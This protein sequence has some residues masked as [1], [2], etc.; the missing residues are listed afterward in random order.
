[1][2]PSTKRKALIINGVLVVLLIAGIGAVVS[3]LR[4]G[5][6]AESTP[7]TA[8][9]TRGNVTAT[10]SASGSVASARERSLGF[11][12]TGTVEKIYVKAGDRVRKGQVLA[13]LDDT[14]ARENLEAAKASL[15][16]A[17]EGDTSTAAGY[18]QYISA[19]NAY[20]AAER[21]L[22]GTV[23]KAP[24]AG[25][26]TA[27]NGSEGGS[28]SGGSGSSTGSGGQQTGGASSGGGFIELADPNR[29]Q[30]VGN[31]TESDVTKIKK[32]QQATVTFDALPG[33]TATGTVTLIDPQP[34]TSNNVVQ[35]AV[36]ISLTDVPSEV[37]LGQTATV[38][39][40][41]GEA[42]NVLTVPTSAIRTAGGQST[43]T[44]I[45]NGTR[46]VRRVEVGLRGDSTT[47][48]RSGLREGELVVRS[49][50]TGSADDSSFPGFGGG[51]MGGGPA[52][53]GPEGGVRI[54]VGGG[55]AR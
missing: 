55:G 44:V 27:V 2:K 9:V 36:T 35:Y 43:V 32:G 19:R 53:G 22:A 41:V 3:S 7:P 50:A 5:P 24:F 45:E 30:I 38:Q 4:G 49:Q 37:R 11:G 51:P 46:V 16:A 54:R 29:L 34:Q 28:A 52:A 42:E 31:F 33:V 12:T 15:E 40:V 1:M 21:T 39:V 23:I 18:A 14:A 10:V 8:R 6:A 13:R 48:I 17:A 20:R 26:V 25:V 47:E